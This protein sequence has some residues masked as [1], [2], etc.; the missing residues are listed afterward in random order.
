MIAD[1]AFREQ[2]N[3]RADVLHDVRLAMHGK[4]TDINK[5]LRQLRK[6]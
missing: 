1:A 6:A 5:L 3:A 2:R 4:H